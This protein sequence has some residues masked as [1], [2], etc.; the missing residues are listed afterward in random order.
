MKEPFYVADLQQYAA[1]QKLSIEV[2]I[3]NRSDYV[4]GSQM[5]APLGEY[6]QRENPSL[7]K[8]DCAARIEKLHRQT[9]GADSIHLSVMVARAAGELPSGVR[10]FNRY[11]SLPVG[12]LMP[13]IQ[14]TRHP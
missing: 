1:S 6:L 8:E 9:L 7:T 12:G 10:V 3:D 4:D 5:F 11:R 14:A 2:Y 13:P